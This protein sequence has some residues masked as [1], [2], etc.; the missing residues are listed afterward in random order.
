MKKLLLLIPM[1]FM[2][3]SCSQVDGANPSQNKVV[4]AVA[5][6]K[7][8]KAGYMQ[9]A[10][11]SWLKTEWEPATSSSKAPTADTSVKIVENKDGSAKLVEVKTGVVLKEMTKEQVVHQ[12]EVSSKYQDEDRSFTLQEYIDKMEVYNDSHISNEKDSHTAKINA[13]PVIGV[14][15]R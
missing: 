6:K 7:E 15:K 5:G 3:N 13:M 8:K 9:N 4:N 12:K 14:K 1:A 10:L 2:M 11:D